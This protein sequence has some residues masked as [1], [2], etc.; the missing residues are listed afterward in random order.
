[1]SNVPRSEANTDFKGH[2]QHDAQEMLRFV[3][4][5]LEELDRRAGV[6]AA[7]GVE[8]GVDEAK[9]AAVPAPGDAGG[10][11]AS[12]KGKAAKGDK[13]KGK[14]LGLAKIAAPVAASKPKA[15]PLPP[16]PE[17]RGSGAGLFSGRLTVTTVCRACSTRSQ[18]VED[19]MDISLPASGDGASLAYALTLA[20]GTP[21]VLEGANKY[22]C[23]VCS[24]LTEAERT[25]LLTRLPRLLTFHINRGLLRAAK[26]HS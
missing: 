22:H 7:P 12:E 2:A 18:R 17:P 10:V 16:P 26:V 25:V 23:G 5:S 4:G 3:L 21:E 24:A 19:F 6:W 1:M 15:P 13:P 14:T 8:N 11:K 9:A 20:Y